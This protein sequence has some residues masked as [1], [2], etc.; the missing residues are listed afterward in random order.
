[1]F[2]FNRHHSTDTRP[3]HRVAA[4]LWV[5]AILILAA[6]AAVLL[7]GSDSL[8]ARLAAAV[9]HR[10]RPP[11]A[12][13][14]LPGQ[15]SVM[16][17]VDDGDDH[18]LSRVQRAAARKL[19]SLGYAAGSRPLPAHTGVTQHDPARSGHEL[20]FFVSGHAP[21]ALL[22]ARSGEI[23]HRWR[24]DYRDAAATDPDAFLPPG[25]HNA[26][27]CWRR[28]HLFPDGGILAIFEG[29]GL[30]KLDR[31]SRLLWAY[32]GH[33][34]HDLH[35][36]DDGRIWV[37]T[38]EAELTP[39]FRGDEPALLDYFTVLSPEGKFERRIP[40]LA[41]LE[42]SSYASLLDAAPAGGD[43][44]H[45][46][47]LE[48]LDGS[49]S[50]LSPI[51]ERG[52]ILT[53]IR[54]LNALAILD[55]RRETLVWALTGPWVKQHQPTLLPT[56]RLL[57]FDN[58]GR[59]GRSQVLEVDPLTQQIVWSYADGPG[60]RLFSATCGSAQRLPGGNTLIVESDNGRALE[61]TPDGAVVW[62]YRNEHRAGEH[63][64]LIAAILD[65][66]ALPADFPLGWLGAAPL[67]EGGP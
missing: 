38:R 42:S 22:I 65:M 3:A 18:V 26:T 8:P 59:G 51:F 13:H 52:N 35:V 12:G 53:S 48:L 63:G 1:M 40:L 21:E 49:L 7:D 27:G 57:L 58:L 54:E 16:E 46:N 15:W 23:L 47:T 11:P 2:R 34:H 32:P 64:E 50:H 14:D 66:V 60:R 28:A 61:V 33:C 30:V 67:P 31:D 41:A 29:H 17:H 56:G 24:R 9:V 20:M 6:G 5:F 4:V 44:F 36:A 10:V 45:T 43:V 39:R 55:P 37:L 25:R 62:E 19:L